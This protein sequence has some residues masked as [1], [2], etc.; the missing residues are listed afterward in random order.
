[1]NKIIVITGAGS[2]LGR[3]IAKR[4]AA[5]GEKVV[6]LGRTLS[7]LEKVVEEIGDNA[8]AISCDIGNVESV[9]RA[10]AE[11]AE[12]YP[13]IDVLINNAAHIDYST[14][15]DSSDEH[16]LN[17]VNTN[18]LGNLL[19]SRAAIHM[20]GHEGQIINVSSDGVVLPYALHTVYQA[21][22]G[23]IEVLSQHL[24]NELRAQGIRVCVVRAGPMKSEDNSMHQAT[25][26]A[27]Q[28][29]FDASSERGLDPSTMPLSAVDNCYWI[30]RSLVD[31]PKDVHVPFI[32]FTSR[33]AKS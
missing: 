23:G 5:D 27:Q 18:M 28:A 2:G 4:F 22:K 33:D 10:F 11:I 24:Q 9:R 31:V 1:M 15:A 13:K 6:L 32:H 14:L 12:T 17:T 7:K 16:L 30:F 26:E 29:F 20:M 8:T 3:A 21:T 25:A 19:C